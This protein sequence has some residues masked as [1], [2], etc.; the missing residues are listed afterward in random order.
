[1]SIIISPQSNWHQLCH[2]IKDYL[3]P[4]TI[5]LLFRDLIH[6][7]KH[8]KTNAD[9]STFLESHKRDSQVYEA[10]QKLLNEGLVDVFIHRLLGSQTDMAGYR[11]RSAKYR[12]VFN[13]IFGCMDM[14]SYQTVV[15][16]SFID[17]L[18]DYLCRNMQGLSAGSCE[19]PAPDVLKES[20]KIYRAH[21]LRD[22]RETE[23]E[24]LFYLSFDKEPYAFGLLTLTEEIAENVD[25]HPQRQN[26]LVMAEL[27]HA[28]FIYVYMVEFVKL[29]PSRRGVE[30]VETAESKQGKYHNLFR[31]LMKAEFT[32]VYQELVEK[33]KIKSGEE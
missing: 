7:P 12:M 28:L 8:L 5:P 25:T 15:I 10:W 27:I 26:Y 9:Y 2:I 32:K 6:K 24:R 4:T 21:S 13:D 30:Y 22:D 20:W 11:E 3:L 19:R 23:E 31:F 16:H 1:M 29:N 14:N 18:K 17:M 33:R